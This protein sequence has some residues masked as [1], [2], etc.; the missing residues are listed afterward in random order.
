LNISGL[1]PTQTRLI[2]VTYQPFPFLFD[3]GIVGSLR[4][5]FYFGAAIVSPCD[6]SCWNM[7]E[8]SLYLRLF[9]PHSSPCMFLASVGRRFR[10]CNF[11]TD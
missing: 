4:W 1:T 10:L 5:I 8:H 7:P 3:P 2:E 6:I 9:T 11:R